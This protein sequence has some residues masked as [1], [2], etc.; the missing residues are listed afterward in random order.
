MHQAMKP[1]TEIQTL[2]D[3]LREEH[4]VLLRLIAAVSA[5]ETVIAKDRAGRYRAP[6]EDVTSRRELTDA[7]LAWREVAR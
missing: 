3:R 4:R 6:N 2:T 1:E 5:V 7:F